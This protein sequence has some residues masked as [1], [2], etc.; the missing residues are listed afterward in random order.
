MNDHVSIGAMVMD[1]WRTL[2]R[3]DRC[4]SVDAMVAELG[5][6]AP[7][8][9]FEDVA[10]DARH[11]A[12]MADDKTRAIVLDAIFQALS[13]ERREA[14]AKYMVKEVGKTEPRSG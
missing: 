9:Q 6:C 2:G 14:A 8:P 1:M 5:P 3:A 11:W 12:A 13:P 10:E 7:I 4:R